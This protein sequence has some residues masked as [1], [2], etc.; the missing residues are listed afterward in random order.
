MYENECFQRFSSMKCRLNRVFLIFIS[1]IMIEFDHTF[2]HLKINVFSADE[3]CCAHD[4]FQE[5]F[6]LWTLIIMKVN[7]IV[8]VFSFDWILVSSYIPP[9][10]IFTHS[11]LSL[12]SFMTIQFT[13]VFGEAIPFQNYKKVSFPIIYFMTSYVFYQKLCHRNLFPYKK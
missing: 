10:L 7:I 5:F 11:N 12:C 13:F 2:K 1:L 6:D 8:C 3:L 9:I 4:F